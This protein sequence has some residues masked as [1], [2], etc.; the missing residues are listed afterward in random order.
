MAGT[1]KG[2]DR[3]TI[4]VFRPIS[5]RYLTCG[6]WTGILSLACPALPCRLSG[7]PS[8]APAGSGNALADALR[9]AGVDGDRPAGPRRGA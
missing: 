6:N 2:P 4:N 3:V 7:W 8:S 9:A 5:D 1:D